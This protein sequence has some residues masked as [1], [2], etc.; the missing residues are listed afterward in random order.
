MKVYAAI[1]QGCVILSWD[2]VSDSLKNSTLMPEDDYKVIHS[3]SNGQADMTDSE[4]LSDGRGLFDGLSFHFSNGISSDFPEMADFAH[5]AQLGGA[6]IVKR[7]Q[8]TPEKRLRGSEQD[9]TGQKLIVLVLGTATAENIKTLSNK[10]ATE[11][12]TLQ[13]LLDSITSYKTLALDAYRA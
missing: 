8:H 4:L 6:K 12:V 2:W 9:Q 11:P 3:P 5:L 1:L 10:W 13:W 7:T